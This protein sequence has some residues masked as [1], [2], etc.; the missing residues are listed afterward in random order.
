MD[1]HQLDSNL[2]V[3]A[4]KKTAL[5]SLDYSSDDYDKIEEE[6]HVLEDH[7]QEKYGDYLEKVFSK[8]HDEYCRNTDV[9]LPIAYLADHYEI[10]ESSV[11]VSSDQGVYVEVNDYPDRPSRLVLVPSP[12]RIVLQLGSEEKKEVWKADS[13]S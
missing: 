11:D 13:N 12:T 5:S 9:L 8:I 1:M 6:L 7:F 4:E 2:R 3:L 10:S